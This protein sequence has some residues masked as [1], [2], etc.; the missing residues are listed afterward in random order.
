MWG[1]HGPLRYLA[2]FAAFLAVAEHQVNALSGS[3]LLALLRHDLP[4]QAPGALAGSE[5][6]WLL[7]GTV[8]AGTH[9]FPT[10]R[11]PSSQGDDRAVTVTCDNGR[12]PVN[13]I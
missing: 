10:S 7:R 9:D 11:T 8:P 3:A 2:V 12:S 4:R 13:H 5:I 6:R 1:N